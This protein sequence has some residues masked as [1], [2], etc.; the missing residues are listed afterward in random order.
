MSVMSDTSANARLTREGLRRAWTRLEP[1]ATAVYFAIASRDLLVVYLDRPDRLFGDARIYF[2]ATEAWLAGS[3][4]WLTGNAGVGFAAPPPALLLNLPL[5]PFGEHVA[6]IFWVAA[7]AIAIMWLLRRLRLPIW[8]VLFYPIAEGFTSGSPDFVLAALALIGGGALAGLTK[9]YS[10]PALLSDHRWRAVGL[11]GVA[12]LVTIP[13][14]P[15]GMFL[16]SGAV[17][18]ATFATQ[19]YPNSAWGFPLLM[20]AAAIALLTLGR[21]R[22]LALFTPA[23]IAQQPHYAL[24]SLLAILRSKMMTIGVAWPGPGAAAFG[25]IL[26]ALTDRLSVMRATSRPRLP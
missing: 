4:P 11:A 21:D 19:A 5:I 18:E 8:W 6:A 7:D 17:V 12:G 16:D 3:N 1:L 15:W 22:A 2:R 24:F 14:L 10:I 23:I 26:Y 13:L 20:I 9:P 25:A